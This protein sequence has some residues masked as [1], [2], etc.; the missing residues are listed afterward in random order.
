MTGERGVERITQ[1]E[2]G[3][4]SLYFDCRTGEFIMERRNNLKGKKEPSFR[5]QTVRKGNMWGGG[6]GG[7][8]RDLTR[9]KGQL[10]AS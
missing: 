6:G 10:E 5:S 7:W 3:P 1:E 2:G 8:G 9:E 4:T